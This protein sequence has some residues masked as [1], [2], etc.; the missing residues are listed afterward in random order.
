M[1]NPKRPGV[2]RIDTTDRRST[3]RS[4]FRED[5]ETSQIAEVLQCAYGAR[6]PDRYTNNLARQSVR[7]LP[8]CPRGTSWD[9][10]MLPTVTFQGMVPRNGPANGLKNQRLHTMPSSSSQVI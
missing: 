8:R 5:Q 6:K 3:F 4:T 2:A 1:R 9:L 10:K 7:D